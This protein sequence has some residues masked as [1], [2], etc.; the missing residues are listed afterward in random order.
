[1]LF[2]TRLHFCK[3][4]LSVTKVTCLSCKTE[5][6][7]IVIISV[8]L[9]LFQ[10]L[11]YTKNVLSLLTETFS[12]VLICETCHFLFIPICLFVA[13]ENSIFIYLADCTMFTFSCDYIKFR[14]SSILPDFLCPDD[15]TPPL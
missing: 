11:S 15:H 7:H 6:R 3:H 13:V 12:V 2:L 8:Y 5:T 4:L 9:L 14:G 10:V 1:M